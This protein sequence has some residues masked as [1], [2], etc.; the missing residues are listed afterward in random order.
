[1]KENKPDVVLGIMWVL[2]FLGWLA[3]I[4]L[5][6]PMIATEHNAFERP[7]YVKMSIYD[8]IAKFHLNKF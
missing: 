8:R 4:G 3:S 2:S 6:I 1:M 5:K 7:S